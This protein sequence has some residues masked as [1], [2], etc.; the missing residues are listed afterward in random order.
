MFP[1][2][3]KMPTDS[4]LAKACAEGDIEAGVTVASRLMARG[5]QVDPGK[6]LALAGIAKPTITEFDEV[7]DAIFEARLRK[8]LAD[9]KA[10]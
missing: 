6:L 4:E 3:P 2:V 10:A 7:A 5:V 1:N 8:Y 9:S